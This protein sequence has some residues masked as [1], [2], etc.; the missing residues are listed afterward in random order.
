MSVIA[1]VSAMCSIASGVPSISRRPFISVLV[2]ARNSSPPRTQSAAPVPRNFI[3]IKS[4]PSAHAYMRL[5]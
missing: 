3:F 4:I 2:N 1:P 5:F